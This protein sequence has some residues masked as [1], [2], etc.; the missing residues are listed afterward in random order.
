MKIGS[1]EPIAALNRVKIVDRGEP[2]VDIRDFCLGVEVRD[3]VCPYLRRAVAGMLNRAAASLPSGYKFQ[4]GTALRTLGMQKGGWDGYFK[5]MQEEHPEWPLSALRRATN[6]FFAPY[7]QP[8]P[9][10][11]CTGAAVDVGLFGPNGQPVDVTS[12]TERWDGAYTWTDRISPE[13]RANRMIMVDA[14]LGAGF[15]NCRD[16]FWHYSYGDSAWAVR[17]GESVCPYGFIHPP[18]TVETRFEGGIGE[19]EPVGDLEWRVRPA[20]DSEGRPRLLFAVC[21]AESRPVT[22]HVESGGLPGPLHGSSDRKEWEPLAPISQTETAATYHLNPTAHRL[23]L[24]PTPPPP[25][26]T[27]DTEGPAK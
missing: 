7:D 23:Y 16:E 18:I 13:S 14:M 1:P 2:L 26:P 11:H 27:L 24:T 4:V 6:R 9:P 17:V 15:S 10:G 25:P 22:L 19:I 8:A 3:G 21:W 12:P 20:A 5:K